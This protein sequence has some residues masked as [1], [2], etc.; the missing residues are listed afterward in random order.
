VKLLVDT[1]V[2]I[3]YATA[4]DRLP[5]AMRSVMRSP[6]NELWLSAASGWEIAIKHHAGKLTSAVPPWQFI[7]EARER[8]GFL[9]LPIDENSVAHLPKLPPIHKDPF[10]RIL[11][12]QSIEH[13]MVIVTN[14]MNI[15]K[16]P[17]R[18]LW[19]EN[20]RPV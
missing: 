15:R 8:L 12:C 20:E 17:V 4:D 19:L 1:Q 16:Y 14:D 5:T 13:A 18:T 9:P 3:W 11:M 2:F 10:D 7:V 6:D